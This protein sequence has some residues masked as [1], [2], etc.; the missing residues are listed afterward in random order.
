MKNTPFRWFANRNLTVKVLLPTLLV[1]VVTTPWLIDYLTTATRRSTLDESIAHAKSTV[2]QYKLLRSYYTTNVVA[3]IKKNTTLDVSYDHRQKDTTIPLPATMIHELSEEFSRSAEGTRL[4]LYSLYP[5]PNRRDRMLDDFAEEALKFLERWPDKEFVRVEKVNGVET[6][7]IAI[8]DRMVAQ[9]CIDCHNQLSSSPKRDWKLGDVR[10]VLE[11]SQP[12][13]RQLANNERIIRNASLITVGG[14]AVIF[15]LVALILRVVGSRLKSTARVMEAVATGDLSQQLP[16]GSQDEVGRISTALNRAVKAL[17]EA[18]EQERNRSERERELAAREIQ[19]EQERLHAIRDRQ[20]AAERAEQQSLLAER[21]ERH[22]SELRTRI[23]ELLTIVTRVE[24]GDLTQQ[25]VAESNDAV[26]Q[27]A[28]GLNRLFHE[29]R[30][31]IAEFARHA[32]TL[33]GSSTHLSVVSTQMSACAE[34]TSTQA[35]VVSTAAEQVSKNVQI[36][37]A[38]IE[39]MGTSIGEIAQN[40]HEAARVAQQAVKA[41]ES[42]NQRIA[43]LGDSSREIGKVV[44]VITSIAEQT[45]LLA[46]NATIEAARAGEAGKGFAIVANEVKDLAKETAA[47]TEDI[48]RKIETIQADTRGAVEAIKQISLIISQINDIAGMIASAV[49]EQT[50]TTGEISR[51]VS[52][53]AKGSGEIAE[54]IT[55]V[56]KAAQST[57]QGAGNTQHA[58]AELSRM[59]TE[60]QQ[61]VSRYKCETIGGAYATDQW[62]TVQLGTQRARRSPGTPGN[63][64]RSAPSGE[65]TALCKP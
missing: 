52:E 19:Q 60:L 31:S 40:A 28:Q 47:A 21:E 37:A 32:Q 45:N 49:E 30:H 50:A 44:K 5:F 55:S 23:D 29:F 24:A 4:N 16:D 43:K 61:L 53:A 11:V 6:A 64:S 51:N 48:S 58:A 26:G 34:E 36:V 63:R 35:N 57:T 3:K 1:L 27:L 8:A 14:A 15:V 13:E 62:S 20:L 42:T 56:A 38:G 12:V 17:R 22:T 9:S 39:E 2:A 46:L 7:R 33:A 65:E 25:T 41:T 18:R 59:A 10:G 54:N